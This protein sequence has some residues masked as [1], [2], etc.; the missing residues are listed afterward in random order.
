MNSITSQ[1]F[2]FRGGAVWNIS[3]IHIIDILSPYLGYVATDSVLS[4]NYFYSVPVGF[5]GN[6][7]M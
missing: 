5:V 3:H 4:T 7:R 1:T 2:G 6:K